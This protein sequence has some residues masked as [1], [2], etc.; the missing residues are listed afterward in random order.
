MAVSCAQN[1]PESTVIVFSNAP[2]MEIP[3]AFRN[4]FDGGDPWFVRNTELN[5]LMAK[6]YVFLRRKKPLH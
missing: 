2:L 5:V 1:K 3:T 4:W 6:C